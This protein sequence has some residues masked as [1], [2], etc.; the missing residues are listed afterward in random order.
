LANAEVSAYGM[1]LC[2]FSDVEIQFI[3][4]LNLQ[5]SSTSLST[6]TIGCRI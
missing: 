4:S 1:H 3:S 2:D 6:P 5:K